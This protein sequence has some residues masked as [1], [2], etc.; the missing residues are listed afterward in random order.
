MADVKL[1]KKKKKWITILAPK[2]F[3]GVLGESCV[4][5]S[6]EAMSKTVNANLMSL[7]NDIKHQAINIKFKVTEIVGDK[8]AT[9]PVSY[10]F[11]PAAIKRIVRRDCDRI[12]T[13]FVC[14][15][16]DNKKVRINLLVLTRSHATGAVVNTLRKALATLT[17]KEV[18]AQPY[19]KLLTSVISHRLQ[20]KLKNAIKKV[21][22]L[23]VCE[24]KKLKIVK[25]GK[26]TETSELPKKLR[27]EAPSQKKGA[28]ADK[29]TDKKEKPKKEG[30][31]DTDE[32]EE[33]R[34]EPED[35]E[36]SEELVNSKP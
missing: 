31:T 29:K 13:S 1:V 27:L 28:D 7:T 25:S 36:G 21:F 22:P 4:T 32:G 24:V 16:R 11:S 2:L 9:E 8:A 35:G 10:E 3:G 15:T 5:E 6:S 26:L 12:D 19:E 23:K 17:V 18:N 20:I 30:S 33:K 14:N 34:E